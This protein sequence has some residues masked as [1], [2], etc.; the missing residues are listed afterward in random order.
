MNKKMKNSGVEWILMIPENWN[1]IKL[2]YVAKLFTGNSI[3]DS[4]KNN[5]LIEN[6]TLPYISTKEINRKYNTVNYDVE[7]HIPLSEKKF[8]V[9]KKDS[10][11]ICIQGGNAGFKKAFLE[12]N[13]CFGAT[14]CCIEP[15]KIESKFIFYLMCSKGFEQE[16]EKFLSGLISGVNVSELTNFKI[17]FPSMEEQKKIACFLDIV[18]DKH[19][20]VIENL[21]KQIKKLEDYKK[22]IILKTVTRGLNKDIALKNSK[23]GR[24]PTHWRTTKIKFIAKAESTNLTSD[25]IFKTG[26]YKVYDVNNVIGYINEFPIR[27]RYISIIKDGAGIGRVRRLPK[28]TI[29]T[30]T[31]NYIIPN[32]KFSLDFLYFFL[33]IIDYNAYS[34]GST[35]PHIYFKDYSRKILPVPP[36]SEQIEIANFLDEKCYFID[37]I[38][39]NKQKQ[40][41]IL[42]E[43]KKSLIYEYTTG[44]KEVPNDFLNEEV[45]HD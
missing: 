43:Y 20:T 2:K 33:M 25:D 15:I 8:K 23:I 10:T 26:K 41:A 9:A 37:E 1:T 22:S 19:Q 32:N 24:I 31:M 11:L 38:I 42:D 6:N 7:F 39:K 36:L 27:T 30:G 13:V 28:D 21:N 44:K 34:T 18:L 12:K 29:I 45:R 3:K 5:Y 35:I 17:P 14:L 16:F 4:E 40:L